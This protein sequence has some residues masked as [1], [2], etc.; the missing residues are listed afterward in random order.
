MPEYWSSAGDLIQYF[1]TIAAFHTLGREINAEAVQT[2]HRKSFLQ[3]S[4]YRSNT[5]SCAPLRA[6]LFQNS[7]VVDSWHTL[8]SCHRAARA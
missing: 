6:L 3:P 7:S 8:A 2:Q 1:K 5:A 4:H